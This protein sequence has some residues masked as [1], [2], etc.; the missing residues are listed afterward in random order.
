M[1]LETEVMDS[2]GRFVKQF[3]RQIMDL[4]YALTGAV[5]TCAQYDPKAGESY[6]HVALI[7]PLS[8]KQKDENLLLLIRN[9]ILPKEFEG[10]KVFVQY[11]EINPDEKV[12]KLAL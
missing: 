6:C 5:S 2:N 9:I 11:M 4:G 12:Q 8:G 10:R 1:S 3:S 7:S